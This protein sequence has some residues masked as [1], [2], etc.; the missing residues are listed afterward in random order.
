MKISSRWV[1]GVAVAA[2]A[3]RLSCCVSKQPRDIPLDEPVAAVKRWPDPPQAG[4]DRRG[5]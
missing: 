5:S 2:I 1:G 3:G 4:G